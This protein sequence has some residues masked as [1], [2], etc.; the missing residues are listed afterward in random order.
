MPVSWDL[1]NLS[2]YYYVLLCTIM[3]G[4]TLLCCLGVGNLAAPWGER[5]LNLEVLTSTI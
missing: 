4:Y 1:A 5:K 2:M 3:Y